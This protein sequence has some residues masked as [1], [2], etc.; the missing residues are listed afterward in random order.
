MTF[1]ELFPDPEDC[2]RFLWEAMLKNLEIDLYSMEYFEQDKGGYEALERVVKDL[3]DLP[4]EVQAALFR[5][6]VQGKKPRKTKAREHDAIRKISQTLVNEY[7]L[8]TYRNPSKHGTP[9]QPP[10]LPTVPEIL[11]RVIPM[12]DEGALQNLV[13][14]KSP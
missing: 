2:A 7:Q 10:A 1:K 13:N 8:G 4:I 11:A 14:K 12:M 5:V 9:T 6:M 3:E